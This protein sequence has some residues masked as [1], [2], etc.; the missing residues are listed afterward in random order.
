MINAHVAA[1]SYTNTATAENKQTLIL[2][3]KPHCFREEGMGLFFFPYCELCAY[4]FYRKN[5][6]DT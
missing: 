3:L 4:V 5:H 6:K 1:V 2:F